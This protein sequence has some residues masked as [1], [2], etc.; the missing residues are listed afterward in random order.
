MSNYDTNPTSN[1][2]IP[3]P[4]QP[5]VYTS[6]HSYG[7]TETSV[8]AGRNKL[9][10]TENV[11]GVPEGGAALHGR[12]GLPEGK[13]GWGDRVVGKMQQEMGRVTDNW[14]MHEKGV[15]RES[16]GKQAVKGEARAPI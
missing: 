13:A 5:G 2:Y 1:D 12:E 6:P 4:S 7:T 16:G 11:H 15:L 3:N 14:E 10:L 9:P 8:P